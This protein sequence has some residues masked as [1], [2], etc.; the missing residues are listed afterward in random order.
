MMNYKA[1]DIV[2]AYK[3]NITNDLFSSLIDL[4]AVKLEVIE[5]NGKLKK[6]VFGIVVEVLQNIYHHFENQVILGKLFNIT[7][8]IK[9]IKSGYLILTGNPVLKNKIKNLQENI[10]YINNM[11]S[12]ELTVTYRK[13]LGDQMFSSKGGAGL[14]LLH[15]ARK[16]GSKVD[17]KFQTFNNDYS[18]FNL[19]VKVSA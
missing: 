14:G 17:Y 10:D 15:L 6:K 3:G 5:S 1:N 18:F 11:S 16:S 13:T 2:L 7:F 9:K 4:T 12:K 19:K 8:T